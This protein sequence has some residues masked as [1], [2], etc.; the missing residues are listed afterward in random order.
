MADILATSSS[1]SLLIKRVASNVFLGV[2]ILVTSWSW[3]GHHSHPGVILVLR[4]LR[5]PNEERFQ[6]GPAHHPSAREA[7]MMSHPSL[8]EHACLDTIVD[9]ELREL[10]A[11]AL[12]A[13]A[14]LPGNHSFIKQAKENNALT[15]PPLLGPREVTDAVTAPTP[16]EKTF[17][18]GGGRG[19][20]ATALVRRLWRSCM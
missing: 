8:H 19:F 3:P 16:E 15:P 17:L 5:N 18:R 13:A 14:H 2:H 4:P 7:A 20:R 1:G 11:D 12:P 9:V 10:L 6:L